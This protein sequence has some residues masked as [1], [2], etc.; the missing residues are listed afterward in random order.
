MKMKTRLI[1]K[2]HNGNRGSFN[3]EQGRCIQRLSPASK[4]FHFVDGWWTWTAQSEARLGEAHL[5]GWTWGL[6]VICVLIF[7]WSKAT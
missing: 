1:I 4:R 3:K 6:E 5:Q 2:A 7:G